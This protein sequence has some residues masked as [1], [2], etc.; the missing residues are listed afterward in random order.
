MTSWLA[1]VRVPLLASGIRPR[2]IAHH[3]LSYTDT[4]VRYTDTDTAIRQFS[5]ISIRRYNDKA[6]AHRCCC[7][8]RSCRRRRH[9]FVVVA[10][11]VVVVVLI[12]LT[13]PRGAVCCC[14]SR[15]LA[16]DA[17][18]VVVTTESLDVTA[19]VGTRPPARH[20]AGGEDRDD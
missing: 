16:P 19:V 1:N 6:N 12:V 4:V 5:K 13:L 3:T 7:C 11:V 14:C 10:V 8:S 18:A 2:D 20:R 15:G 17:V 9:C